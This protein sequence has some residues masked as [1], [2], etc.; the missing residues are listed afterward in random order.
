MTNITSKDLEKKS[1][2]DLAILSERNHPLS[3][4]GVLIEKEWQRRLIKEQHR[5]NK[6]IV[7]TQ[8]KIVIIAAI[9]TA[10]SG[11]LGVYIGSRLNNDQTESK[12][13]VSQPAIQIEK[14]NKLNEKIQNRDM[15]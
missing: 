7:K 2:D 10:L 14:A 1:D 9:I 12:V 3:S 13:K 15:E 5:L 6:I 11:L 8:N 4:H